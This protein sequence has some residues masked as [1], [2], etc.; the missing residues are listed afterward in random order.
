[1]LI[2]LQSFGLKEWRCDSKHS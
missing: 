2:K 1:M